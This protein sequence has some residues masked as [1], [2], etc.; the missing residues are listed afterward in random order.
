MGGWG[1]TEGWRDNGATGSRKWKKWRWRR[2]DNLNLG[3][4]NCG[5]ALVSLDSGGNL[6]V[7]QEVG[8][9]PDSRV[10]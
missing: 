7:L 1:V 8:G 2:P 9:I 5:V 4:R 6:L 3:A 10:Y